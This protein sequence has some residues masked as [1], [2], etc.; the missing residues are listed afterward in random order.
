MNKGR[1]RNSG[2]GEG[3]AGSWDVGLND[4]GAVMPRAPRQPDRLAS[5]LPP[6]N[7][8]S[9]ARSPVPHRILAAVTSAQDTF[10][11]QS[12]RRRAASMASATAPAAAA[13]F[14]QEFLR[15]S[16][17]PQGPEMSVSLARRP[18]RNSRGPLL[19]QRGLFRRRAPS[20]MPRSVKAGVLIPVPDR[21]AL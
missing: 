10:H 8:R 11:C 2:W 9:F 15:A 7:C 14:S 18:L 12:A 13:L 21:G 1:E 19:P 20:P 6:S 16:R 3:H 17:V 4:R 5:R